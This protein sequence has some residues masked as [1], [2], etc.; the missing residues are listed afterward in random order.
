MSVICYDSKLV[1]LSQIRNK[2]W[3]QSLY[4]QVEYKIWDDSKNT[5]VTKATRQIQYQKH[6]SQYW[7]QAWQ[8]T[9]IQ[10]QD[11]K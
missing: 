7:I 2:S 5:P 4:R 6:T 3:K 9:Q 10:A 1:S 11:F 8:T